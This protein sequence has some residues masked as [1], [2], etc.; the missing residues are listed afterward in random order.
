VF[1]LFCVGFGWGPAS[2]IAPS[3]QIGLLGLAAAGLVWPV[4]VLGLI[5]RARRSESPGS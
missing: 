1:L 4:V 3:Q 5:G 2:T